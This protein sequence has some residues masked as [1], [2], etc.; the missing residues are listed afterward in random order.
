MITKDDLDDAVR[1]SEKES[2]KELRVKLI[3]EMAREIFIKSNCGVHHAEFEPAIKNA[4]AKAAAFY[5]TCE[6]IDFDQLPKIVY[7]KGE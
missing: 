2:K 3:I 5:D 7:A 4:L 1:K 6:K